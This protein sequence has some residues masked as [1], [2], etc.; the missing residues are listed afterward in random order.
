[1]Y[2]PVYTLTNE[3]LQTLSEIERLYGQLEG[4]QIPRQLLLNLER[5]NLVKSTYASNS[6][7]GNPLS[8]LEVSNL[9]L[10]GRVAANRDEKEITNYFA[11]LKTLPAMSKGALGIGE[12]LSLHRMLMTG[13][14]DAIKGEIRD[15]EVVVGYY[16]EQQELVVK[17][18]PPAHDRV[19]IGGHLQELTEW[20]TA[21]PDA[22]IL[23]AGIFHH[24][25]VYIHPFIDGNGRVCRLTTALVLLKHGYAINKYFLLDDYYDIDRV[26]YSDRLHS[27]DT[28]DKTKWLE[29]FALGVKH[30]LQS[31]LAKVEAGMSRL[32][33]TMRPTRREQ[34]VLAIIQTARQVSSTDIAEALEVTRQQASNLLRSLAQKSYIERIGKTKGSYY[35]LKSAG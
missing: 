12:M 13:V 4:K 31:A 25:F 19:S 2:H 7:E 17:H 28:G 21:A 20:V 15:R 33:V 11:L 10:G 5:D 23:K 6:I 22:P 9:L 3:L 8:H 29:Y 27:A 34:E 35:Q 26:Q 1:M 16:D 30:S 32:A 24:E 14:D 18:D